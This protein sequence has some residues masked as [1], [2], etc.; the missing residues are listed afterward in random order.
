MHQ[1][2]HQ[3]TSTHHCNS[4]HVL[5]AAW[6]CPEEETGDSTTFSSLPTHV[7]T[8]IFA[9]AGACL[10]TCKA[11]AALA[12]DAR[13]TAEWLLQQHLPDPLGWA[14]R[15]QLWEV[16][17]QLLDTFGYQPM[18]QDLCTGLIHSGQ[19]G[20]AALVRSLLQRSCQEQHPVCDVCCSVRHALI[21]AA[22][23]CHVDV[24]SLLVSHPSRTAQ[25]VRYA[26][27]EAVLNTVDTRRLEVLRILVSS[28]PDAGSPK[29][30]GNPMQAAIMRGDI[31]AMEVL[32][33]HGADVNGSKGSAW[34]SD[35]S[36]CDPWPPLV[37]AVAHEQVGAVAWLLQHGISAE[38]SGL[39]WALKEAARIADPTFTR[40][41]LS[42]SPIA[43]VIPSHGTSALLLAVYYGHV[44]VAEE[45]LKAGV[46]TSTQAMQ[47]AEGLNGEGF[48]LEWLKGS[49]SKDDPYEQ[50][51][52]ILQTAIQHG[53]ME[54]AQLL[55]EAIDWRDAL[56]RGT[57][58]TA[59][60]PSSS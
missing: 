59:A 24:V 5:A 31:A 32:V 39:G 13:L 33:Q 10:T 18:E 6:M 2:W 4:L 11:S 28:C 34:R 23:G 17:N 29:L 37:V 55:R 7:Q 16:C 41:L 44:A 49:L 50:L 48:V 46:P 51:P 40:M 20:K 43:A 1:T 58:A 54:F 35:A 30:D 56:H 19:Y 47:Q 25:A 3:V 53:H 21:S 8:E 12:Q 26:V 57:A 45:L 36:L 14:A 9:S 22:G 15:H 52:A 27:G 60:A 42:H 38:G